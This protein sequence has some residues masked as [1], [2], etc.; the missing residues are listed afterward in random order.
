MANDPLVSVLIPVYNAEKYFSDALQS[1]VDQTY[2]NLEVVIVDDCSQD[3]TGVIAKAFASKDSRVK[4]FTNEQN[5]KLSGALNEGIK[6]CLGK[7]IVRMDGD[8]VSF[9]DRIEKQVA[10][11]EQNPEVGISGGSMEIGDES[12]TK[13]GTRNY[14]L[15]DN[16]IRKN[17]FKFSPFCHPGVIIRKEVFDLVGGY[18]ASFTPAEDYELY[19]RI[20]LKFNFGN[21]SDFVLH[22]RTLPNSMTTSSISKM[23]KK[24]IE[25]RKKYMKVYNAGFSD[26]IY[27][28]A[29]ETLGRFIPPTLKLRLFI[30]I[31]SLFAK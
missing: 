21:I 25:V 17:I 2:R 8:D 9:L 3:G 1:I 31:R 22:Y 23:E 7:Y 6:H 20:G 5:L 16:D 4:V 24:T 28:Y 29:H 15:T 26:Y 10:Y 27:T 19:F 30:F 11:M 12:L 13:I 18:D 14:Y